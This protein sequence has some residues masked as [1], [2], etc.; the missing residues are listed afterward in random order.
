MYNLPLNYSYTQHRYLEPCR[1]ERDQNKLTSY[2]LPCYV[3]LSV[4]NGPDITYRD[5]CYLFSALTSLSPLTPHSLLSIPLLPSLSCGC[6]RLAPPPAHN[7][8]ETFT[9]CFL[10]LLTSGELAEVAPPTPPCPCPSSGPVS[11]LFL[12][13]LLPFLV[14]FSLL[15]NQ[16]ISPL[17]S[18]FLIIIFSSLLCSFPL[19]C[20]FFHLF[21]MVSLPSPFTQSS[22]PSYIIFPLPFSFSFF[23]SKVNI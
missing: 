16:L 20:P 21:A 17:G 18:F 22:I 7:S 10:E 19:L 8:V 4:T 2:I 1:V 5:T 9:I 12:P 3:F 15:H 6:R 13:F 14:R 23:P 11:I